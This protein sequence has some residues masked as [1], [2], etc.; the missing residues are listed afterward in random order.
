MQQNVRPSRNV[1][2]VKLELIRKIDM[3]RESQIYITDCVILPNG[4]LLFAKYNSTE[5]LE[6]REQGNYIDSIP[7][8]TEPYDITVLDSDRIAITYGQHHFFEIFNYRDRLVEK[9]INTGRGCWGVCQSKGKIYVKLDKVEVFDI[10]GK[11]LCTLKLASEGQIYITASKNYL[12]SPSYE[13]GTV[14]CHDMNGQEVWK[15][16]DDS[17]KQ[18]YGIANDCSGNVFVVDSMSKNL[19]IIQHDGK[20]YK[21]LL[22][23]EHY[24]APVTVCYNKDKSTIL[25]C[26]EYGHHFSL[27]K[28]LY[29]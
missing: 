10:T 11:K 24:S 29:K 25:I 17:L 22:N 26:D 15:F 27:Y 4:H 5:L 20:T 9:K 6:Y 28:V 21:N 14:Y 2:D 12:F 3:K 7:V 13:N 19:I 18:P 16:R 23:L 1:A 8:S